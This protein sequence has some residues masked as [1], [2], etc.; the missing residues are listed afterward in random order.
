M[1]AKLLPPILLSVNLALG[2]SSQPGRLQFETRCANC[3]G[4]DGN[5]GELGP[6]IVTRIPLRDDSELS[7]LIREGR[8]GWGMPA[9]QIEA[10]ELADLIR[11]LRSMRPRRGVAMPVSRTINLATGARLEGF[12]LNEGAR[13]L[14]LLGADKRLHILRKSPAGYRSVTSQSDWLGYNGRADGNRYTTL[15]QINKSNVSR[16]AP[17]WI[18]TLPDTSQLE[19]TPVVVDGVMYVTAANE[20]YALDGG[21]GRQ[22]WHYRR[23][24]TRGL[25][26]N[27]AGGLNRGVAVAGD[28]LFMATDHSHVISLNRF[29]GELL[30]ETE[31]ADW[32]Q[33]YNSTA[34]PLVVGDLVISGTAGGDEGVRGFVAAYEQATGREVWRFWT[35]PKPGEPGSET[36]I[37]KAI[38]HGAAATWLT[39]T[40]D[41]QLDLIYW[42]TGN[43]GPDY[44]GSERLGD[45]LY[46]SSVVA[47][48]AKTGK[49]KWYFQF[50]PHNL[51]DWDSTQTPVLVDANWQGRP[52]KLLLHA[53]RN[54]FFYVLDRTDGKLLLAKQFIKNLTWAKGIGPDGR[55]ILN[56]GQEPTPEGTT[57]CPSMQGATNWFSTAF[58]PSTGL[59][60]VSTL[61]SCNIFTRR[62]ME[63]RAGRNFMAGTNI[64]GPD[65]K[66]EKVLRA[67]DIKTGAIAWELPQAGTG[68][69]WGG[70]LATSTGLVF[71]GEDGYA[72]TALD[73]SSGKPIWQF[74]ANQLWRG[75]PMTYVFDHKQHIAVASGQNIISFALVDEDL[76]S[77][78]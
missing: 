69:S 15:D 67:I 73:A 16:L 56:P 50:T 44:D 53:N 29:T 45:N 23:R 2:Q 74:E 52:R 71:F 22:I 60:Y 75:S 63:W 38:E 3:H 4:G 76:R 72:F 54:G 68:N 51:W 1:L 65:H 21:T 48:E 35:V 14:Q 13:D 30:W 47:L 70:V 33:N 40:Y 39:G 25:I 27:A 12:V 43:P 77:L 78:R 61:E 34:A 7:A 31:S 5:G 42:T 17:K 18:F 8:P 10:A 59:Y 24:R 41:S 19:V 20:C 28:R 46:S 9:S 49:L 66:M 26:G 62:T 37:G 57:V 36:W 32:R 6:A 58:N 64:L 11:Y 55:P